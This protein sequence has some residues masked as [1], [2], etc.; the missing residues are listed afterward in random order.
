MFAGELR[1]LMSAKRRP[2][3]ALYL[4]AINFIVVLWKCHG[5]VF[6]SGTH[7]GIMLDAVKSTL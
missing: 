6:A 7:V 3:R 4:E 2:R 1:E 5:R